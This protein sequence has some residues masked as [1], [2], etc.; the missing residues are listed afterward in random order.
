MNGLVWQADDIAIYE[1]LGSGDQNRVEA[2]LDLYAQL[3]PQ[4]AHYVPR[5]RQRTAFPG[6]RDPRFVVHYWLVEVDGQPA[7][8]RTFRYVRQRRC[9]LAHSLAMHP[10]YRQRQVNGVR[11][12]MFLVHQCLQQLIKDAQQAGDPPVL[13][14]VN[15]VESDRLMAHYMRY[16]ATLLP[17]SYME[18][19]FPSSDAG[20]DGITVS[21][22]YL[23]FLPVP[24]QEAIATDPL[25][26]REFVLA[27]LV[28][29][30]GL[31]ADHW[32]VQSVLQ[33][34]PVELAKGHP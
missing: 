2:M 10:A 26:I 28:D 32:V 11:L 27:F 9:G 17:V 24:G 18:P 34:I 5:M 25:H 20:L 3:F 7:G 31:P 4:Y 15:E 29:H 22:M 19:I 33:S 14:M 1:L 30:Y 21:P 12:A 16:G 13:G 23:G 8:F 6:D